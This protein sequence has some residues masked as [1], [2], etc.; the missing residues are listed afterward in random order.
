L[1]AYEIDF[2]TTPDYYKGDPEGGYRSYVF[3]D[4][5]SSDQLVYLRNQIEADVRARLNI[6]FNPSRAAM[7]FE[8]SMGQ[9]LPDFILRTSPSELQASP[10]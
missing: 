10:G 3:T 1:Y 8:H 2:T 5:L 7:Q 6:P 4:H 9:G